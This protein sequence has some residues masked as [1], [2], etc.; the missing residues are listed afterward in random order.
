MSTASTFIPKPCASL[1]DGAAG[2]AEADDPQRLVVQ[3]P[4]LL[5]DRLA[6]AVVRLA[7][8]GV[9]AARDR[10]Q[11]REGVLGQVDA[12]L[13]PFSLARITL[14]VDQSRA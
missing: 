10:E 8:R 3:L 14:A 12:D 4:L 6:Q 13:A 7:Q 5:A 11:E 1:R 9:D 2:A